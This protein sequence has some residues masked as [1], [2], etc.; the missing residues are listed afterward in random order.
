MVANSRRLQILCFDESFILGH[1][2]NLNEKP[3]YITT[4]TM[5]YMN[6]EF[7]TFKSVVLMHARLK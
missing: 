2:P 1:N 6:D 4:W 3:Q 5:E 7:L